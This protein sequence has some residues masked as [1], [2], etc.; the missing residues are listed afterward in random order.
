MNPLHGESVDTFVLAGD[1]LAVPSNKKQTSFR[2]S[3]AEEKERFEKAAALE[4]FDSLHAWMVFHLRK[5]A[6]RTIEEHEAKAK[7]RRT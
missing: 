7:G 1:C 3:D 4:D 5:Q 6:R 2:F